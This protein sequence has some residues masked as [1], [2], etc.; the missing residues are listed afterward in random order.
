MTAGSEARYRSCF[1]ARSCIETRGVGAGT[2]PSK[3]PIA[4][5]T[6]CW[7]QL[8]SARLP[9]IGMWRVGAGAG[10]AGALRCLSR[11]RLTA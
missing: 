7:D 8:P 10:G 2:S 4:R 11:Q 9:G 1:F 5:L 3:P 6:T